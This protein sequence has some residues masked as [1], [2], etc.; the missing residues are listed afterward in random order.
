MN[1]FTVVWWQ[2][3]RNRLARLWLDATDKAAITRAADEIDRRLA[4]NPHSCAEDRHEELCRMSVEPL[5]VQFT[6]NDPDRIVTVWTVRR[7]DN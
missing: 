1:L 3:A 5:S 6:V 7:S 4:E 2:F